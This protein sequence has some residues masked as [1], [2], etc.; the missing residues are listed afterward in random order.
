MKTLLSKSSLF[1]C[2]SLLLVGSVVACSDDSSSSEDGKKSEA[3]AKTG[4][5]SKEGN[6]GGKT[7]DSKVKVTPTANPTAEPTV[8]PTAVPTAEPTAV[9]TAEP[10]A[11]PTAVPTASPTIA[12]PAIPETLSGE[13]SRRCAACHEADGSGND[14]APALKGTALSFE[15]FASTV[16]NGNGSMPKFSDTKYSDTALQADYAFLKNQ[17]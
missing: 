12:P 14:F 16:R 2:G 8:E 5:P 6:T 4:E 17:R 15:A 3:P 7:D 13:F 11:E 1:I 9:P 10:T